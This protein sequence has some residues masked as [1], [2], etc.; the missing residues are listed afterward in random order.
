MNEITDQLV[1]EVEYDEARRGLFMSRLIFLTGAM[2]LC[3]LLTGYW[4]QS[5][6]C[7]RSDYETK[8][9]QANLDYLVFD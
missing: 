1:G 5:S 4:D 2:E 9:C 3:K 6:Y 8:Q 7:L